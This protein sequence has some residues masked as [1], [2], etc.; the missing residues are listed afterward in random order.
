ML[1]EEL[2]RVEREVGC[3]GGKTWLGLARASMEAGDFK[4]SESRSVNATSVSVG[5]AAGTATPAFLPASAGPWKCA[6]VAGPDR[7]E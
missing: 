3:R 1:L 5:F 2:E 4:R 7:P 6:A